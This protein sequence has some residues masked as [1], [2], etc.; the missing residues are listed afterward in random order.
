VSPSK[1]RKNEKRE[2]KFTI[3]AAEN[4]HILERVTFS[5]ITWRC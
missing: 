1:C 3:T 5:L 2:E 4:S